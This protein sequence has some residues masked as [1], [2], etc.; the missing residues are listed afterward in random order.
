[1]DNKENITRKSM[2][3]TENENFRLQTNQYT[4]KV[5]LT[6]ERAN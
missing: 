3:R 4:C 1:M 2:E 6:V 5:R